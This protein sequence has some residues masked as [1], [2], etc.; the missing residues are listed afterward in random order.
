MNKYLLNNKKGFTLVEVIIS[1]A[2]LALICAIGLKLFVLSDEV[3]KRSKI[4]DLANIYATNAIEVCKLVEQPLEVLDALPFL[5]AEV[6][7]ASNELIEMKMYFDDRF[8]AI[9]ELNEN[10]KKSQ[11][12]FKITLTRDQNDLQGQGEIQAG[13]Y[14]IHIVVENAFPNQATKPVVAYRTSKYYVYKE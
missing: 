10:T 11:Y 9:K 7:Q 4:T 13:I 14:D 6:I 2:V 8:Q 1:I 5:D 12:V 3:T